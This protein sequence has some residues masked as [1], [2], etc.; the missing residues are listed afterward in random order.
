MVRSSLLQNFKK[1]AE[2][3]IYLKK[4]QKQTKTKKKER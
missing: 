4:N 1:L 2:I 3:N